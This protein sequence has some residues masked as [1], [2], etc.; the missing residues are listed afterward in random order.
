MEN[1]NQIIIELLKQQN[2][3][4]HQLL[5]FHYKQER[6]AFRHAVIHFLVQSIPYIILIVLGIYLY[7]GL[8]DYLE[9]IHQNIQSIQ[10]GYMSIQTSMQGMI[11][12]ISSIP[13]EIRSAVSSLNP[14]R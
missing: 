6:N 2:Q 7:L 3:T 10:N 1:D 9:A 5:E 11:D 4:L 13:G 8:K 12:K 14:F